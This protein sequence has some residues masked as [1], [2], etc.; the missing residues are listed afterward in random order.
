MEYSLVNLAY[1]LVN[2]RVARGNPEWTHYCSWY[3]LRLLRLDMLRQRHSFRSMATGISDLLVSCVL[4][5][6]AFQC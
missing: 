5:Y 6:F 1:K 4:E 2:N 3:L